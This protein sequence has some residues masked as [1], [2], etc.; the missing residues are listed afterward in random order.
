MKYCFNYVFHDNKLKV[1]QMF[2]HQIWMKSA[3]SQRFT[4]R[5]LHSA[6]DFRGKKRVSKRTLIL[7]SKF[8]QFHLKWLL[9]SKVLQG[10]NLGISWC[11]GV[12]DE[13]FEPREPSMNPSWTFLE[14]LSLLH[15]NG[16]KNSKFPHLPGHRLTVSELVPTPTSWRWEPKTRCLIDK[17]GYACRT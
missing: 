17:I 9:E 3:R 11:T 13:D 6:F 10:S 15:E 1:L 16:M 2:K 4:D 12:H 7:S 5:D 14:R 8:G